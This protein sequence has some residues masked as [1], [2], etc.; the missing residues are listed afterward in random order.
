M[1]G[2]EA[3]AE[4]LAAMITLFQRVGLGPRDVGIKVRRRLQPRH[5]HRPDP[6]RTLNSFQIPS[7]S[8]RMELE[9]EELHTCIG[10]LC[11]ESHIR[12]HSWARLCCSGRRQVSSRKVLQAVLDRRK[13]PAELFGPV[14]VVVDK[15]DKIGAEK[16]RSAQS[17]GVS[18]RVRDCLACCGLQM[19][20]T[21]FNCK[22]DLALPTQFSDVQ[23]KPE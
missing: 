14:C 13:V 16:V 12:T 15:I 22:L 19:K 7:V 10:L 6:D 9:P 8:A 3:E 2:V 23:C 4:L 20:Q 1:E 18:S 5:N 11:F 21:A 17:Q